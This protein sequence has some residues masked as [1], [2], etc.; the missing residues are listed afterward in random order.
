[1]G[2]SRVLDKEFVAVIKN[3]ELAPTLEKESMKWHFIPPRSP[4]IGGLW[5]AGV[6]SV[7]H[8]L[9]RVI[10]E[11]SF[12]YEEFASLLSN[13]SSAKL[14]AISHCKERKRW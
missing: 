7:K 12:T 2:A 14:A 6:K 8:H 10:G 5:E 13:R 4:H 3:N 1:V 11:N 9:K